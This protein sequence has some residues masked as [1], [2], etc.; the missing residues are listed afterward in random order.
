MMESANTS[1]ISLNFCLTTRRNIPE[2]K[3]SS[4][5]PMSERAIRRSCFCSPLTLNRYLQM[6]DRMLQIFLEEDESIR[7]WQTPF[8]HEEWRV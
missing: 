4:Y 3:P 6:Y 7:M 8:F 1:D 2:D 5:S